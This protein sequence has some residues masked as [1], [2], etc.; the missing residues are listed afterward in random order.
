MKNM[1]RMICL[2]L[3][4][5]ALLC[6]CQTEQAPTTGNPTTVPPTTQP[7]GPDFTRALPVLKEKFVTD[8]PGEGDLVLA[9]DGV[10]NA[11][12]VIPADH[13][14]AKAAAADLSNYL[15][16]ITG[17]AFVTLTDDQAL[18]EG[19]LILVGPTKKTVEMGI[20]P[21]TGYKEA[22]KL[23]ISRKDNCLILCGND[24]VLYRGTLNAV[25]YFLEEAGCGWFTDDALWQ[26]VPQKAT[27]AVKAVDMTVEP[28]ISGRSI[29]DVGETMT[30]R[31]YLGGD[32]FA[33][34]HGLWRWGGEGKYAS[35]PEWFA[36]VK[37]S[38]D[39]G[40]V[41]WWQYC[42][43]NEEFA[44]VVGNGVVDYFD[45]NPNVVSYSIASND[46][47]YEG[48]CE[49]ETCAAVGN[50]SDQMLLFANRVAEIVAQKYPEKRISFLAYHA[51]FLPPKNTVKAYDNVE[52]RFCIETSPVDDLMAD[53]QVHSGYNWINKL[54]YTQS[55]LDNVNEWIEKAQLQNTSIW[56]WFCIDA[57]AYKWN[58]A[59]WVQGNVA[60]RNIAVFEQL[61]VET[62][63]M[64]GTANVNDLR[65]P[66]Y[67]PFAKCMYFDNQTGEEILYD[68]C[69]KLYGA[70]ADEMF[71]YY[72]F[73][74][75]CAQYSECGS[76]VNWVP[77]A[78]LDVYGKHVGTARKLVTNVRAKLDQLTPEQQQRVENQLR[79]WAFVDL[80]I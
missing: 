59:P 72:R 25:T 52:V 57:P 22:E 26:I 63:F 31:W 15:Q 67:Y 40:P 70:A 53:R 32:S 71:L 28:V 2:L 56:G 42:Y 76:G 69:Q 12:I 73:L 49:C 27:L 7:T 3:C 61:G 43:T 66:L 13:A 1:T 8:T 10:A 65:W 74:A 35:H 33:A 46:G 18:P 48:W 34:G 51:T 44:Q 21:Y 55:W 41:A 47:W 36:L 50:Q 68:A 80:Y 19:N 11:T 60:N 37:G 79:G 77:P 30:A 23:T 24:D 17:A 45:K 78:L 4:L 16:R 64:D 75:D 62:I 58:G 9:K 14:K 6:A 20:G 39:P 38:R 5:A 54:E 29:S